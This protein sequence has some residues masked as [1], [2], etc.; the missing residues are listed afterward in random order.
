M[1]KDLSNK[2]IRPMQEELS[3]KKNTIDKFID[4]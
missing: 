1:Q 3:K 2:I 4:L